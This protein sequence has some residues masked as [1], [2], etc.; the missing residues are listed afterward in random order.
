MKTLF[1]ESGRGFSYPNVPQI[2]VY[3]PVLQVSKIYK[4]VFDTQRGGNSA[5]LCRKSFVKPL[6]SRFSYW[7]FVKYYGIID[8]DSLPGRISDIEETVGF[9]RA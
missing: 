5:R 6:F 7:Y 1:R 4:S 9:W 2:S 3:D 8:F